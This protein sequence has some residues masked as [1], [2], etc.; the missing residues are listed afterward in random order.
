MAISDNLS[1]SSKAS[2]KAGKCFKGQISFKVFIFSDFITQIH[3]TQCNF[4]FYLIEKVKL[5]CIS[6]S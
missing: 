5:V 2:T 3:D 6:F 1:T 4:F